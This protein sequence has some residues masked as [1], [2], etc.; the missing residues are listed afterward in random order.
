MKNLRGELLAQMARVDGLAGYYS[1]Q[2]NLLVVEAMDKALA[3]AK[4]ALEVNSIPRMEYV[5]K[6]L[7]GF[8]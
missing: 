7:K 5:Y 6:V 4:I 8:E 3:K 1:R 2:K